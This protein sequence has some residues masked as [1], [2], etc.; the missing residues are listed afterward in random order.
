MWDEA[1][2]VT[3]VSNRRLAGRAADGQRAPARALCEVVQRVPHIWVDAEK[4]LQKVT[5]SATRSS[6]C[7]RPRKAP[8]SRGNSQK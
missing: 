1:P 6:H 3:E 4:A 7:A 2:H 5:T 8:G